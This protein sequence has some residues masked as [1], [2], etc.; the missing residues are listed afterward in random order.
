M[1]FLL[2]SWSSLLFSSLFKVIWQYLNWTRINIYHLKKSSSVRIKIKSV[3]LYISSYTKINNTSNCP[4]AKNDWVICSFNIYSSPTMCKVH[5]K[6]LQNLKRTWKTMRAT[7][8]NMR[9][10]VLIWLIILKKLLHGNA[11]SFA[12]SIYKLPQLLLEETSS[13][14][15]KKAK[16]K[17]LRLDRVLRDKLK[18]L[19]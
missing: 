15:P 13:Q 10:K 1:T 2:Q 19:I 14:P 3:V 7:S 4:K 16:Q 8:Y 9:R 11:Y 6:S 12:N 5:I 18:Q 17:M